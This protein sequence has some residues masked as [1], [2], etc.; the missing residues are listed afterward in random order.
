MLKQLLNDFQM[1]MKFAAIACVLKLY[2]E[3]TSSCPTITLGNGH[4]RGMGSPSEKVYGQYTI[5]LKRKSK[6]FFLVELCPL[7]Y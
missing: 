2:S 3:C 7:A 1:H 5:G 4:E 6:M